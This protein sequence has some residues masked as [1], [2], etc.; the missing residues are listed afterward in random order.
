M[1][2]FHSFRLWA[3]RAPANQRVSALVGALAALALLVYLLV[4]AA[5]SKRVAVAAGGGANGAAAASSS[6]S[7]GAA[8]GIAQPG[9][10]IAAP[11]GAGPASGAGGA[12]T[13][14]GASGTAAGTAGATGCAAPPGSDQGITDTELHVAIALVNIYGPAANDT[15]GIPDPDTQTAIWNALIDGVN[16]QGGIACR[17]VVASF[18]KA[19]PADPSNLQATCRDIADSAPFAVFDS[20]SYSQ[21][22]PLCFAQDQLPYFGGYMLTRKQQTDGYPYLFDLG[23]FDELFKD[24]VF[25]FHDR[26][27]FDPANGFKKLG[28]FYHDCSPELITEELDS[29]HQIGLQ[30]SQISTYNFSCP[31]AFAYPNDVTQAVLQFKS[32]GVTHV[33][34]VDAKGD[35]QEWTTAA[36]SQGYRPQYVLADDELLGI[37]YGNLRPNSANI[38]NAQIVTTARSGEERTPGSTPTAG[39]QKCDA[40]FA[41]H[42]MPP[43]YQQEQ[44]AGNACNQLWMLQTAAEHASS[45]QRDALA[46]GLHEAQSIDFSY[47]SGPN[48]FSGD[49]VT[50][51]GQFWRVDQFFED[52]ACWKVIDPDFHR[53]Y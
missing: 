45:L 22:G 10:G 8:G 46:A 41:A 50:T 1:N 11:S 43:T 17:K 15:F 26:R 27:A 32:Q 42:G 30:D 51:A 37:A 53:N 5:D 29:L 23:M 35:F 44:L 39:T 34:Y 3:R 12:V 48:D 31:T 13:N 38:A 49:R 36:E 4:P 6:P 20:G 16:G 28:V 9:S 18:Y 24:S 25:A 21:T 14:A 7:G 2:P 47:P 33:T 40:L 52:C 19:N